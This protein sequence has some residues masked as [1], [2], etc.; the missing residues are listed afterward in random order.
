MLN[1]NQLRIFYHA[2]KS[3]S[4]TQ[5]ARELYI[6]QPAVTA[7]IKSLE[8]TCKFKLFNKTGR[9]LS[10]TPEARILFDHVCRL[11]DYEKE[12]EESIANM[13]KLAVGTLRIGTTKTYARFLMPSVLSHFLKHHPQI[14]VIVNEGSSRD[15]ILDLLNFK[16]HVAFITKAVAREEVIFT[17]FTREKLLLI[18][19]PSHPLAAGKTISFEQLAKLPIIMKESGSGTRKAVDELFD[20]RNC[21]PRTLMESGNTEL[22]KQLV[23]QGEG[24]S[25]LVY[26]AV[27]QEISEKRLSCV[28][29]EGHELSLDV[30]IGHLA[31]QQLSPAV[32]AFVSM[33]ERL[34][35]A[36]SKTSDI[37]MLVGK[38]LATKVHKL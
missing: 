34:R 17:P 11:F 33:M 20:T 8:S 5:A 37:G 29:L 22:I 30:C 7:Q 21:V 10:L 28:E 4:F 32:Q 3:E 6:T 2:A 27:A 26:V 25:F 18:I 36:D 15:M 31:D 12:V 24:V 1:L 13:H 19:S 9:N 14:K 38:I 23:M 35:S 16:N